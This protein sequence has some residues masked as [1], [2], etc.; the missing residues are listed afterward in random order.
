VLGSGAYAVVRIATNLTENKKYAIKSY[1]KE[2]LKEPHKRNNLR[3]E[4]QIMKKLD[5]PGI[6]Q[7]SEALKSSKQVHIVLEYFKGMSLSHFLKTRAGK[8]IQESDARKVFKQLASSIFY[9]HSN[10]I[11]HRDIKLDN[12]LINPNLIV[13]LIDFGFSSQDEKSKAFCGTPNY[14][15]PEIVMRKEH[16]TQPA[17]IWALG[18]VL[19][20]MVSGVFPF[21]ALADQDLFGKILDGVKEIP[22]SV[23]PQAKCLLLKM[24]SFNP[25]KRP[26]A[27]QVLDDPWIR[28]DCSEDPRGDQGLAFCRSPSSER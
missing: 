13:K 27:L 22:D 6:I 2:K 24:L 23:P 4:I 14:M 1:S 19:Y 11:S 3:R 12:I 25:L 18:V 15:S 20:V 21:K 10:K 28:E 17:D 9:L 8:R 5:H 7:M 16:L 26:S